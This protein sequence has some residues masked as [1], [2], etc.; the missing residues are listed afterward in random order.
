MNH[1]E[2]HK[3][4]WSSFI[5]TMCNTHHQ[6]IF[7]ITNVPNFI[8]LYFFSRHFCGGSFME[9]LLQLLTNYGSWEILGH[10]KKRWIWRDKAFG[11]K[12][13]ILAFQMQGMY[14]PLIFWWTKMCISR[15][16]FYF[17]FISCTLSRLSDIL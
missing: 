3:L 10:I 15:P 4:F 13:Q 17:C 9:V 12:N 2:I 16:D 6:Y 14:L 5:H 1:H 11:T 8:C 7:P